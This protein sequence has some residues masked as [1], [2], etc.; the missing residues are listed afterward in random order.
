MAALE[1]ITTDVWWEAA[2]DTG[3]TVSLDPAV[4]MDVPGSS[5]VNFLETIMVAPDAPA[6]VLGCTVTFIANHYPEEGAP[7]G[8]EDIRITVNPTCPADA[9]IDLEKYVNGE[10]ADDPTG[11]EVLVG[12]EVTFSYMVTNNGLVPLHGMIVAD[13][14]LGTIC[15]FATLAPG[16]TQTC[17]KTAPA[18]EGQQMNRAKA[19]ATCVADTGKKNSVKDTDLGH[20]LGILEIVPAQ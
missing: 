13:D 15:K 3:L 12:S 4:V 2:C 10:D 6:G 20:Y 9:S 16:E 1:A 5:V 11:P 18:L 8:T 14:K 17:E 19:G 7:I